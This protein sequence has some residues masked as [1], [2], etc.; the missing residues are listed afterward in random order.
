MSLYYRTSTALLRGEMPYR[1]FH[2]EYPPFSLAGFL[3]P[4]LMA[5]GSHLSF[6]QYCDLFLV[7]N[8]ALAAGILL[9]LVRARSL[10]RGVDRPSFTS[11]LAYSGM[12]L[13]VGALLPW[14]YDLFPTALTVL[15]VCAVMAKRPGWAGIWLGAAIAAKLYPIVLAP[16]FC[17]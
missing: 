3:P 6:D 2:L 12:V 5:F 8:V 17:I 13:I 11:L 9:L 4:H 15:A 14:R 7:E 10:W 1:D 16:I